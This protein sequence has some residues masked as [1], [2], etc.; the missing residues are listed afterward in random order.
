MGLE[1]FEA[2]LGELLNNTT[3]LENKMPMR[4]CMDSMIKIAR[5]AL[6]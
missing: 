2:T 3:F 4:P 5:T 1:M 6:T